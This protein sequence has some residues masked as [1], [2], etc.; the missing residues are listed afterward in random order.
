MVMLIVSV[1]WLLTI[2]W[3]GIQMYRISTIHS[4]TQKAILKIRELCIMD[5]KNNKE[6]EWRYEALDKEMTEAYHHTLYMF[7]KPLKHLYENN[8]A[9]K[10]DISAFFEASHET[11]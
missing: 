8:S 11:G 6:W 7:W 2:T 10:I 1:I 5:I 4:K 3:F 9:L